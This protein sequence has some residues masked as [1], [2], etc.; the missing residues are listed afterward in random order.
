LYGKWTTWL[1]LD[2][3]ATNAAEVIMGAVKIYGRIDVLVNNVAFS[4]LACWKI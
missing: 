3:N 4:L 2:V 1:P